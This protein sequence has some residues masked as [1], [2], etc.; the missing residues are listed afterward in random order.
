MIADKLLNSKTAFFTIIS[1]I[2]HKLPFQTLMSVPNGAPKVL[3]VLEPVK[4][5]LDPIPVS[6]LMDTE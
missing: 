4:T 5:H 1:L 3:Y 2:N 6:A